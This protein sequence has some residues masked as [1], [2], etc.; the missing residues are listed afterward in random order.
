[1]TYPTPGAA[2]TFSQ[3]ERSNA[4][5]A[6]RQGEHTDQVLAD[7]LGLSNAQIGQLHDRGLV[8]SA[9]T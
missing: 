8:A 9:T 6:P 3:I 1:L 7:L 5:R 4:T 2:A